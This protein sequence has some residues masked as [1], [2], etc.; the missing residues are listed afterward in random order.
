MTASVALWAGFI[1][2]RV[3]TGLDGGEGWL[4]LFQPLTLTLI[5]QG[6]LQL[7]FNLVILIVCGRI[8]EGIL[9]SGAVMTLFVAGAFAA[10]AGYFAADPHNPALLVGAG[11]AIGAIVG[12]YAMLAGRVSTRFRSRAVARALN[13][14]WLG[15][16]WIIFQLLLSL[17]MAPF[18]MDALAL[19]VPL[20]A[21][22]A[23]GFA[24]G[25]L[26]AKPLLLWKWRGA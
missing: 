19:S 26:L 21:A 2:E 11:G 24:A 9:G 22:S 4:S 14:A 7:A 6:I 16:T 10:A 18:L 5:H 20:L 1:P 12:A 8:V 23:A 15:A 3:R 17:A 13:I 25:L